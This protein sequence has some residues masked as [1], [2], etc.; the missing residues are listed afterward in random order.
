MKRKILNQKGRAGS[1]LPAAG[2][3]DGDGAHGATRP[4]SFRIGNQTSFAA[5]VMEPFEFAVANGFT[6]FEFFPDCGFSDVGGWHE[7]DL[8]DAARRAI[9]QMA[10]EKSI[11]LTVHAPLEFNPLH[12]NEDGRLYSTIEF[13]HALG[14]TLVNLHLEASQGVERFVESLRPALRLTAEAGL[15]LA[16]ENTVWT[17]PEDFNQF[18]AALRRHGE[19]PSA[20]AGMCFDL[21]HA[22]LFGATQNDYCRYLD[23]LSAQV[24]IIHLHLHENCGDR[25]SHLTLFTGPLRENAAGIE[26]LLGRL[27]RRSFSGCA[28]LE[29]WPQPPSLLVNARDRLLELVAA[30]SEVSPKN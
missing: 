24:P 1:P 3:S 11:E 13:A 19:F 25:D 30:K 23:S 21:G 26:G 5:S 14:A 29:Q 12:N 16:I 7:N 9:R 22:N 20:H 8:N 17:G 27:I 4:S 6:A 28:I 15:K 10:S 18:F 2:V